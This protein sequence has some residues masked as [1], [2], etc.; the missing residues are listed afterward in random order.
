MPL[1]TWTRN[2]HE[3]TNGQ[4][5]SPADTRRVLTTAAQLLR[6]LEGYHGA[7]LWHKDIKPDNVIVNR[8]GAHL[9]DLGLLTPI[10]SAM[11]LTTHGT[12]YFRDPEMVKMALRGAKVR[13]VEA[14]KFDIY[15]VGAVVFSMIEDS[16]PAHG[17]LSTIRKP[18]PDAIRWIVRRSMTELDRRYESVSQMLKDVDFVLAAE[19][20]RAVKPV[21]LPSMRSGST[22]SDVT[23]QPARPAQSAPTSPAA[24][25]AYES[26]PAID[27]APATAINAAEQVRRARGRAKAAQ[28]RAQTRMANRRRTRNPNTAAI[29]SDRRAA[30][31]I[32]LGLAGTVVGAGALIGLSLRTNAVETASLA[33]QTNVGLPGLSNDFDPARALDTLIIGNAP[34]ALIEDIPAV[35]WLANRGYVV[36]DP[37]SDEAV[38]DEAA[39]RNVVGIMDPASSPA[40]NA[41]AGWLESGDSYADAIA[42]LLPDHNDGYVLHIIT[43]P[44]LVPGARTMGLQ[45]NS[46]QTIGSFPFATTDTPPA[47]PAP[48]VPVQHH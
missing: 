18:C 43:D 23:P 45:V 5:L 38:A 9:V 12:E 46:S 30:A 36:I 33:G 27:S 32:F 40:H 17:G 22:I 20:M 31:G 13:D 7:G 44:D 39:A 28:R 2:L 25:F 1:S 41:L 3:Q 35:E 6:T 24:P 15:G 8:S 21:D 47:P 19:D 48:P 42:W 37:L 10:T 34:D 16:F 11:T 26:Q 14:V 4:G 29:V